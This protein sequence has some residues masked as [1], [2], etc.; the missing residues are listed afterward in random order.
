MTKKT[1]VAL[2]G[3]VIA[4]RPGDATQASAQVGIGIG[5]GVPYGGYVAWLRSLL[6]PVWLLRWLRL[7]GRAYGWYGGWGWGRGGWGYGR[8]YYGGRGIIVAALAEWLRAGR[9]RRLC[10]CRGGGFGGGHGGFAAV[11]R[12]RLRWRTRRGRSP[13][14]GGLC[15][16]AF[17]PLQPVGREGHWLA[18]RARAI[19]RSAESEH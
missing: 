8:G 9:R 16:A 10:W 6:L 14:N 3:L 11:A 19:H 15:P 12:R 18:A 17:M 5:V 1:V 13:L 4:I 7:L 2:F